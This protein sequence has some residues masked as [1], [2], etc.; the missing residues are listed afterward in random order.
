MEWS[1][2]SAKQHEKAASRAADVQPPGVVS[3]ETL[4]E[5]ARMRT[6]QLQREIHFYANAA[7]ANAAA[8]FRDTAQGLLYVQPGVI[9]GG[10]TATQGQSTTRSS[11]DGDRTASHPLPTSTRRLR[12]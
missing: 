5:Y 12:L 4:Q 7:D 11:P 8:S 2:L 6:M 9:A 10:P 1:Q 3:M